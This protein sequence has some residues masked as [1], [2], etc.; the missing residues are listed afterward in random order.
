MVRNGEKPENLDFSSV[1]ATFEKA[2]TYVFAGSLIRNAEVRG[3]IPLCS[4][5][6][7][8]YLTAGRKPCRFF[9]FSRFLTWRDGHKFSNACYCLSC[10]PCGISSSFL[11]HC[12]QD[13]QVRFRSFSA[14]SDK[15]VAQHVVPSPVII[16]TFG[17][18]LTYYLWHPPPMSAHSYLT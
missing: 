16:W 6:R 11:C 18:T 7:I 14:L 10:V 4:T 1:A 2:N 8:K 12:D 13:S 17:I 9:S 3:S 5:K 15:L